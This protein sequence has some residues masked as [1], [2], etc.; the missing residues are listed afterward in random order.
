MLPEVF[1]R[2]HCSPAIRGIITRSL[3]SLGRTLSRERLTVSW[4][5]RGRYLR[6]QAVKHTPIPSHRQRVTRWWRTDSGLGAEE[7]RVANDITVVT[8][9]WQSFIDNFLDENRTRWQ[10]NLHRVL[11]VLSKVNFNQ[12]TG[13]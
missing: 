5:T 3:R 7:S 9:L 12:H 6:A 13:I 11:E 4:H 2:F 1:P 10:G 8:K